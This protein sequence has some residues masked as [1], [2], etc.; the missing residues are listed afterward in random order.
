M[1]TPEL[2]SPHV[3][4]PSSLFFVCSDTHAG[5]AL[6][7]FSILASQDWSPCHLYAAARENFY[8]RQKQ[9]TCVDIVLGKPSDLAETKSFKAVGRAKAHSNAK[10]S[11][12]KDVETMIY[13]NRMPSIL[14][15]RSWTQTPVSHKLQTLSGESD[16]ACA[17]SKD[18]SRDCQRDLRRTGRKG[19]SRPS[20]WDENSRAGGRWRSLLQERPWV[21]TPHTLQ[22]E[23]AYERGGRTILFMGPGTVSAK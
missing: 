2:A 7:T 13:Q 21:S 8:A 1:R 16:H 23:M 6:E 14:I 9:L 19:Q 10:D 17:C 3:R 5:S 22:L 15:Y 12:N 4:L 20:R 18:L 11:R